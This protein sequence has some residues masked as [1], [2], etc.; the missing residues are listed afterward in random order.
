MR[1]LL[2]FCIA[3]AVLSVAALSAFAE[4]EDAATESQMPPEPVAA[5]PQPPAAAEP[6][7]PAAAPQQ[8]AAS[9]AVAPQQPAEA[10]AGG[11]Q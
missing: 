8:P 3:V 4:G 1:R 9:E 2:V 10:P 7:E 5:E 6:Q 11:C